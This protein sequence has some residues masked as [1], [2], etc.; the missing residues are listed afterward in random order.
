MLVRE[1]SAGW[2]LGFAAAPEGHGRGL[3]RG[4]LGRASE[5][6]GQQMATNLLFTI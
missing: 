4:E 3:E 1:V 5:S 6:G 2:D